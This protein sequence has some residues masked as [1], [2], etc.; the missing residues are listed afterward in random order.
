MYVIMW[1]ATIIMY[2][3]AMTA[4]KDDIEKRRLSASICLCFML[5]AQAFA[6]HMIEGSAPCWVGNMGMVIVPIVG[7]F[8]LYANNRTANGLSIWLSLVLSMAF[9][10]MF[11]GLSTSPPVFGQAHHANVVAEETRRVQAQAK[12]SFGFTN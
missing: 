6:P 3:V 10:G 8:M 11:V 2:I 7:Y 9:L 4:Y 1:L 5:M 12:A